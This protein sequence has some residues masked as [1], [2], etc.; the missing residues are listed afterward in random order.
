MPETLELA[1]A[2]PS[3]AASATRA[4]HRARL[5]RLELALLVVVLGASW[6]A[7]AGLDWRPR[8]GALALYAAAVILAQGLIRDLLRLALQGRGQV[9]RRLRCLCAESTIGVGLLGAGALLLLLGLEEPVQVD[10]ARLVA[11]MAGLLALGF[12]AKDYVL[13]LRREEDHASIGF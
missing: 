5:V 8:F 3:P 11:G 10:R 4:R 9:T 1:P 2:A 13:V 7:S 6:A 12:V